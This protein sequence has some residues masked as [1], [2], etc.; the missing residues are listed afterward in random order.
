M[1]LWG[2]RALLPTWPPLGSAWTGHRAP[3]GGQRRERQVPPPRGNVRPQTLSQ[4]PPEKQTCRGHVHGKR[5][6]V[7]P[8]CA[9]VEVDRPGGQQPERRRA[10]GVSATQRQGQCPRSEGSRPGGFLS[11]GRVRPRALAA[12]PLIGEAPPPSELLFSSLS[13]VSLSPSNT[14]QMPRSTTVWCAVNTRLSAF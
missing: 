11:W 14:P 1:P 2:P 5:L 12:L 13:P 10:P 9:S 7:R 4:T 8:A 3:R 6:R